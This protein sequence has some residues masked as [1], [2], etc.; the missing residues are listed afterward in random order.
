MLSLILALVSADGG[1]LRLPVIAMLMFR[2]LSSE[3]GEFR[4]VSLI[5]RLVSSECGFPVRSFRILRD[6]LFLLLADMVVPPRPPTVRLYVFGS[7][8]HDSL[9]SSR[10]LAY[11]SSGVPNE[12]RVFRRNELRPYFEIASK[13]RFPLPR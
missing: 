4:S 9:T 7:A 6:S 8:T 3:N 2:L 5:F 13:S 12:K 1:P 10:S 11:A